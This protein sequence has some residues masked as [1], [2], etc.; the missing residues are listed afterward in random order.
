MGDRLDPL[1]FLEHPPERPYLPTTWP[2]PASHTG[3]VMDYSEVTAGEAVNVEHHESIMYG[4]TLIKLNDA[5]YITPE[6]QGEACEIALVVDL[7]EVKDD[8]DI[9]IR[10]TLQWLWR[11]E[12][13]ELPD[14][15]IDSGE[16]ELF[17][18]SIRDAHN[19]IDAIERCVATPCP[20]CN[21]PP[22]LSITPGAAQGH[23]CQANQY[24]DQQPARVLLL[25]HVPAGGEAY[26]RAAARWRARSERLSTTAL[27]A[28]CS[29]CSRAGCARD[30]HQGQ[31]ADGCRS[32]EG[33]R[34]S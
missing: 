1:G 13:L 11:P 4:D 34:G 18:A 23:H 29:C 3:V 8:E 20:P 2:T 19:P 10:C 15:T 32:A 22:C 7:Y 6:E 24:C 30:P 25:P 33:L 28:G 16:H 27:R 12:A 14:D 5:V 26:R 17:L 31:E 9:P 21:R